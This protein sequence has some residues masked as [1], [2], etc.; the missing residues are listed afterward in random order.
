MARFLCAVLC[1]V[2]FACLLSFPVS[3]NGCK[4][5]ADHVAQAQKITGYVDHLVLHGDKLQRVV[6]FI[7]AINGDEGKY[8][9]G[10]MVWTSTHVGIFVGNGGMICAGAI[11]DISF[12]PKLIE[13]AEGRPA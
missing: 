9:T 10:Y 7:Q 5:V 8:D 4:P 1:A 3:A 13:A 11:G 2:V 6:A 12:L